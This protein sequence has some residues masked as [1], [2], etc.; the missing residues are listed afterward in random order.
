VIDQLLSPEALTAFFKVVM[1]DLVLAG[2]NAIVIGLAAAGLPKAQR[3]K[4]ILVGVAAATVLRILFA[5]VAVQLL[6]VIGLVLV[7]GLLL[8]WVC[9]K[10]WREIKSSHHHDADCANDTQINADGT[11][12]GRSK[13]KSFGQAAW[14]ILIADISMSLDNVLAVAGAAREHPIVLIFGLGLSIAL[15][16]FAATFIAKLLNSYRWIAYV[17]LLI[18]VYVA[19]DMIVRGSLEVMPLVQG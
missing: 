10:M 8:L 7:G 5:V 18:I 16:G 2:D 19:I 4:A 14:Q 1:I 3:N 13:S 9:W 15:M 11:T 12:S 17:G 6:K